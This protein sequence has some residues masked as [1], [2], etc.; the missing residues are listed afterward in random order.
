MDEKR[1]VGIVLNGEND[2]VEFKK[3]T[4][5]I[6][7]ALKA[8][9]GFLNHKGGAVYFGIEGQSVVGQNVA[10]STLKSISQKIR[11][12]IKPEIHPDETEASNPYELPRKAVREA[13]VNAIVHRD[14]TSPSK[15]QVRV[16]PD[17]VEIWNP[18]SLPAQLNVDNLK[19]AHP[20][21]PYNP[22][23]FK[24]FYKAAY[25]EDVGGGTIDIIAKCNELGL[26]Q[27][28]FKQAMGSF[29]TIIGRSILTEES[30]NTIGL[31][32]RQKKSI[33]YIKGKQKMTNKN[34]Q[35]IN[36]VSKPTATR[37]LSELVDKK[38]F[39]KCGK[40]GKGTH[41]ILFL[42]AHKGLI[43]GSRI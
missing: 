32:E 37:E 39:T 15:V 36:N 22:L 19:K 2:R 9:C 4:A 29:I 13:I 8:I 40:T 35:K 11:Q 43:K 34:Y 16:F 21:V 18:G 3:S 10:E 41:Y 30:L 28:E 42:R 14:Y 31:N 7:K 23:I 20:S 33:N 12:K 25:V 17:R 27:P 5:Q 24:Q 1:L 26:P 38:I 6:D